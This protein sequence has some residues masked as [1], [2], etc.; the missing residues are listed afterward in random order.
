MNVKKIWS[1]SIVFGLM[2]ATVAYFAIFSDDK[3]TKASS[4]QK[5]EAAETTES[6]TDK[7]EKVGREFTNPI[8]EITKGKRAISLTAALAE[9]GSGYIQPD[10]KVDVIAFETTK[11]GSTKKEY[12][13]AV[14][15][16]ENVK[17]L[18]SGKSSNTSEEALLYETVTLEVTPEE[19]VMLS[20]AAK[21]K[22]GFY[23]MLRNAK[24]SATGKI[25]YKQTR[26][27]INMEGA[28]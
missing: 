25:H 24:D 12:K 5:V 28:Q 21:D 2:A 16:L 7:E 19:G 11:H 26:E 6:S 15:V 14:L 4:E 13:S 20:L 1:L 22:D 17:V 23:F 27:L 10:S 18:A 8:L 9:G 3:S